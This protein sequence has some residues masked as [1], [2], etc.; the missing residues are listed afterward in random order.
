MQISNRVSSAN[1]ARQIMLFSQFTVQV[2]R[3][4]QDKGN[5]NMIMDSECNCA[6][7]PNTWTQLTVN[8]KTRKKYQK[9]H[10]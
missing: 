9:W 4:T 2:P 7:V 1:Y 5:V 10:L 6:I 8:W 3:T